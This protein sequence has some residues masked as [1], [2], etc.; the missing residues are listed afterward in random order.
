MNDRPAAH[1][2]QQDRKDWRERGFT[3]PRLRRLLLKQAQWDENALARLLGI[4]TAEVRCV[5]PQAGYA[6]SPD[7][8]WRPGEGLD[9]VARRAKLDAI[10]EDAEN[11]T[12]SLARLS[13][14]IVG[15]RAAKCRQLGFGLRTPRIPVPQLDTAQS[16]VTWERSGTGDSVCGATFC[17]SRQGGKHG[18]APS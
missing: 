15:V 8:L 16:G 12:P 18:T 17:D 6:Q 3:A 7:E 13:R 5:L 10:V 1:A 9:A 2:G 4:E 14:W 11:D